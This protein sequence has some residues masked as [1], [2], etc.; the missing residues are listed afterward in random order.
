MNKLETPAIPDGHSS[1]LLKLGVAL[2]VLIGAVT[3]IIEGDHSSET[4]TAAAVAASLLITYAAGKFAQA[5]AWIRSQQ[6]ITP[7]LV[8]AQVT[9]KPEGAL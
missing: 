6:Q 4:I 2:S 7:V 5:N 3:A 1:K 8:D 9:N